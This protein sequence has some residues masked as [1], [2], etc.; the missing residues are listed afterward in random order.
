MDYY[1]NILETIG[2]TP[3][4]KLNKI[5][6]DVPALVLA[7]VESFNPGNSIK[8]RMALKMVEDA[9][10][11]GLLKPGGTIIECTSGNTGMGIA[12]AAVV[13]GYK[14]IFTSS[15]KQSKEKF[16][17]LRAMGAEVI[18]CPTNVTPD[19]PRSYYSVAEKLSKEIPNSFWAN[20]YDNHSNTV[21][22]YEST[23]PE[24]WEQTEG[25]IT[26][27]VVGVGTGGTIS[28]T[29]KYLKEKNPNIKIWGVDTYGSV[30]KKY[31]ETGEFDEKEIYP[32]I[33]EGIGEDILPKNVDFGVIDYFEKVS[34]KDAAVLARRLAK[35][36]GLF[37]GYS[38]G[39]AIGGVLQLKDK[40]TKD[41]VVVV[42]LHDHGSRYVGKIYNDD[43]M[44]DRG[45]LESDFTIADLIRRKDAEPFISIEVSDTVKKAMQMMKESDISQMPV[46][47][48]NEIVGS[49]NESQVLS[50]ILENPVNN[51]D[52]SVKEIMGKPFPIVDS[53][54]SARE[55]NKYI[56]KDVPAVV[57]KSNTGDFHIV[58]QY[59]LI[60]AL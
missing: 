26:H 47:E 37:M 19:D 2:N 46:M 43:W 50:F 18:V 39:S 10:K 8:D 53:Q 32:Y 42:I 1:N 13:K 9:E 5:T 27:L 41:D 4:V 38:A 25:K 7:K 6:S 24:I 34:D 49:I 51:A 22:H 17:I 28:G 44:R 33:T 35:E 20:Q 11:S 40:L 59:D 55:L 14:C 58:T 21:A 29:G 54:L 45:F 52:K 16:D 36:E 48:N 12:L 15:D 23:G 31:H 3:M 60:Q 56:S 57:S 30:F